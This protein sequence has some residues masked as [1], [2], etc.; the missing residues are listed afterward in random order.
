MCIDIVTMSYLGFCHQQFDYRV[1]VG[2]VGLLRSMR[3][4]QLFSFFL[5]PPGNL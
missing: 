4:E 2:L 3:L 1:L 5:F